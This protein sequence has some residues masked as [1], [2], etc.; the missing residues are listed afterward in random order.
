MSKSRGDRG[1]DKSA[2]VLDHKGHFLGCNIFGCYDEVAFVFA[3][4]GVKDY[5][6]L[7]TLW[8]KKGDAISS[9]WTEDLSLIM[10]KGP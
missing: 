8:R 7:A 5:D 3:G 10:R 2:R 9:S 6:E 4:D 1:A